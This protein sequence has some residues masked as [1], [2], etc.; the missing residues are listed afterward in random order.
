EQCGF[1]AREGGA[2]AGELVVRRWWN[3]FAYIEDITVKTR[4]RK[5]GIGRALVN[6]SLAW[7]RNRQLP[8]MMLE[9]QNNNVAACRFYERCGFELGG[10]DRHLYRALHAERQEIALYWYLLF[11]RD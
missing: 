9:T 11:E 6:R 10:C 5:Q 3:N 7:A 8:G 2:R 4:L 1:S